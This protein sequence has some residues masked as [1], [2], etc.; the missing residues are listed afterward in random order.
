MTNPT[1]APSLLV[2][3]CPVHGTT[4]TG[5]LIS[6]AVYRDVAHNCHHEMQF[7]PE[8]AG[9]HIFPEICWSCCP[10]MRVADAGEV[11]VY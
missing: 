4:A 11:A 9:D 8:P 7:D 3:T 1:V 5:D 6:Q 2:T 10:E